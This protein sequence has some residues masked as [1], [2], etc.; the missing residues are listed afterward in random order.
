MMF[1]RI[2]IYVTRTN[3]GIQLVFF[4]VTHVDAL[5]V[6]LARVFRELMIVERNFARV[7]IKSFLCALRCC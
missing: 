1:T 5:L 3:V 6:S 4:V 2:D 7:R